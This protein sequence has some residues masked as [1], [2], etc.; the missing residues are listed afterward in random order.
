VVLGDSRER[1]KENRLDPA[2]K[3]H[4]RAFDHEVG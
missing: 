4:Q 2:A 3:P 1:P